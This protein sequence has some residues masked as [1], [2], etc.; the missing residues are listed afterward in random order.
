MRWISRILSVFLFGI[1]WAA[2]SWSAPPSIA[3]QGLSVPYHC[4]SFGLLGFF[5]R[6]AL[7]PRYEARWQV[8]LLLLFL[9]LLGG[10]DEI[11]QSYVPGRDS[12]LEDWAVDSIA[13]FFGVM[14]PFILSSMPMFRRQRLVH[15]KRDA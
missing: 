7:A 13:S 10:T 2:S 6:N 9:V 15:A 11:H 8:S 1:I 12:S 3:T 5:L 14:G 4:I